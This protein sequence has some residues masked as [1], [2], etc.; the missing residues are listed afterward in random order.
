MSDALIVNCAQRLV[1]KL[2]AGHCYKINGEFLPPVKKEIE[3][4]KHL[5][6][7]SKGEG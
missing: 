4:M 1:K 6:S 5:C 7:T 3:R 2:E